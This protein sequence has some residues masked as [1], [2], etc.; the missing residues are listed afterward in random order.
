[1]T[2]SLTG[3]MGCG[4]STVGKLLLRRLPGYAL[5][6][7]DR[8]IEEKAGRSVAA[9]FEEEGEAAFRRMEEE[10]LREV[11][12]GGGNRILSLGGG[13]VMTPACFNLVHEHSRCV[14]IKASAESIRK[15]LTGNCSLEEAAVKRPVLKGNGI[16]QLLSA[17]EEV[18]EAVAH[19]VVE[20]DGRE[21]RDIAEEIVW[22]LL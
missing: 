2:I 17:R 22:K 12:L 1:M 20:S 7:L 5:I 14:Y 18:Y 16:E 21:A 4:K 3:F 15:R 19:L 13:T 11:L 6:D 9:I 8:Y 10:C